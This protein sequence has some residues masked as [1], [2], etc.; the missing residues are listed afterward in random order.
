MIV[1]TREENG[2]LCSIGEQDC[3]EVRVDFQT[4]AIFKGLS[5]EILAPSSAHGLK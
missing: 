1:T 2:M 3:S 5:I 4:I